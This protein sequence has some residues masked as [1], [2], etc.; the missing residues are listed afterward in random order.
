MKIL[1]IGDPHGEIKDYNLDDIDLVIF[2]GDLGS[3][4]LM[5]KMAFEN[6]ER[7]KKGL[8]KKKFSSIEEKKAYMEAYDSTLSLLKKFSGV[9]VMVIYGNVES[10][11]ADTKKLM[12]RIKLKLPLLSSALKKI[13]VQVINDKLVEFKGVRVGGLK[14]F[15]D[16]CWVQTFKPGDYN[17]KMKEAKKDSDNA[18]KVLKTFNKIDILVCHQPPF[19]VLDKVTSKFAPKHWV[20]KQAGSKVV[21]NYI[22]KSQPKYVVCG[23][24]HE[25]EGEAFVG[26]TKVYNLGMGSYKVLET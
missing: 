21:L 11:D 24:I 16:T 4:S 9:P 10:S 26:K 13:G 19:G 12:K 2:T 7:A 6:I 20:G 17:K 22:K 25:G 15:I 1:A 5:R 8:S 3:A 14:Y 18:K 23:H